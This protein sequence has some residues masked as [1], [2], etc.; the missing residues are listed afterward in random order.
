MRS[1]EYTDENDVTVCVETYSAGFMDAAFA[2]SIKD[3]EGEWVTVF[4]NPCYISC[5]FEPD[6]SDL[7]EWADEILAYSDEYAAIV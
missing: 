6:D 1:V 4:S 3:R 5:E 7:I 2:V